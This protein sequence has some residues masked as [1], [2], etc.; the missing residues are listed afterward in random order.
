MNRDTNE[1]SIIPRH[2][3]QG[4]RVHSQQRICR[5]EGSFGFRAAL[6]G[7]FVST[8]PLTV[9]E[10]AKGDTELE[11]IIESTPDQMF[12]EWEIVEAGKP[13]RE[14]CIPAVVLNQGAVRRL[15][16]E[17]RFM[18]DSTNAWNEYPPSEPTKTFAELIAKEKLDGFV[19]E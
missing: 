5:Q 10:E 17:E 7:V 19:D 8:Y 4:G 16:E 2:D 9:N 15:T 11:I 1:N 13:Y 6:N 3:I 14:W 18:F 12:N